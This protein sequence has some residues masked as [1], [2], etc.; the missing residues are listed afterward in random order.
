M[1][2]TEIDKLIV[3]LLGIYNTAKDIHYSCSGPNFYGDHLLSDRIA[4]NI[5]E[6]IDQLKEICLLGR[7]YEPLKSYDYLIRVVDV[8]PHTSNFLNIKGLM[9]NTLIHI[10]KLEDLSKA[11]ENLIGAI[12]QDIQNNIGL[13]NIMEGK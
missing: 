10:E 5:N 2:R 4:E 6:Y 9:E 11:D 1:N 3:N 7:G 8:I 12:A 13:L